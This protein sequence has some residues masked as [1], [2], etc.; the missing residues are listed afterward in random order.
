MQ[1]TRSTFGLL[2]YINTSKEKKSGKCPILGRITVDGK[3][4]A[5]STGL[6]TLPSDWDAG[7]GMA[8]GK[9]KENLAVNKQIEACKAE[10]SGCYRNMLEEKGYVTAESLKNVFLGF[11]TKKNSVMGEFSD[12][13]EE[14][15]K[16]IG[17]SITK[18]TWVGYRVGLKH[19]RDFLKDKLFIDD[20]PFGKVDIGLIDDYVY[21][22]KI[23]LTMS[24]HSVKGNMKV[25][26]SLIKRA[27]NRRLILQDPFFDYVPEKIIPK[28]RWLS[29][30]EVER[31]MKVKMGFA[32][33]EF[34]KDMFV[35]SCFT[36]ICYV[37]LYNLRHSDIQRQPDGSLMIIIK[38]QKT[39]TASYIPLLPIAQAILDKYGDSEFTGWG[40]K[41]FRMQTIN[42]MDMHLKHIAKA[43]K[44]D[45]RL[46]FH[47]GRHTCATTVCLSHGVPIETLSRMLGHSSIYTTQIYAEVTRTKLNE[48]MTNLEKRI[49]GK[50]ELAE[51]Q[52]AI[53]KIKQ[54]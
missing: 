22:L 16:S 44:V 10:I 7:R 49:E 40:G 26:R 25:F 41:V 35:F 28:R 50:Y 52:P 9:S 45:K 23:D 29:H 20:I 3:S 30:D 47:M 38:R 54:R 27:F 48:D 24:P 33:W 13:V 34:T 21:Y 6:E 53:K 39:S 8:T 43:A 42:S 15:E 4:T 5:F 36:G 51:L 37:D 12:L 14:K 19:F 46:T 32:S 2:F 18:S 31:I 1:N 11:G 17:I